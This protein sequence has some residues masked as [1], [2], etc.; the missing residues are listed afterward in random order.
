MNNTDLALR[1]N[2]DVSLEQTAFSMKPRTLDEALKY[3]EMMSQSDLVPSSYKGKPGNILVAIQMGMELGMTPMRALRSIAVING[4]ATI[5]G[6]EL[7]AMVQSSPVCEWVD[8]SESSDT[9]GICTVKRKGHPRHTQ[10]FTLDDAKRAG[11]LGKQGPWQ[12]HTARM[13]KLRARGFALRDKF[14]DVLAGL[15]TSEEAADIPAEEPAPAEAALP[16]PKT[17]KDKLREQV[18]SVPPGESVSAGMGSGEMNQVE[19]TPTFNR[20]P[21][22]HSMRAANSPAECSQIHI[23]AK[24]AGAGPDDIACLQKLMKERCEQLAPKKGK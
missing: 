5:W 18:E 15:V 23:A 17:L 22:E 1:E 13:L 10:T 24:D 20:T 16:A 6:D 14:A 9:V 7:L 8:E 21:Y 19:M 2:H 3:A 12:Q 4:R 11:L